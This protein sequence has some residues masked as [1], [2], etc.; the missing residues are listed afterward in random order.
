MPSFGP[1]ELRGRLAQG[2]L[3]EIYRA[4]R[5]SLGGIAHEVTLKWLRPE[6]ARVPARMQQLIEEA[7]LGVRLNHPALVRTEELIEVN[8][9]WAVVLEFVNGLDLM[10]LRRVLG[11]V[12]RS[13]SW[14]E[15]VYIAQRI[16]AGLEY[17][18]DQHRIVHGDLTPANVMLSVE[19]DVKLIDF[20]RPF[21]KDKEGRPI[22][23]GTPR[24]LAPETLSAGQLDAKSD[25]YATG[26]ILWELLSGVRVH[27]RRD[28]TDLPRS[29][30]AG[31]TGPLPL[32]DGAIPDPLIDMVEWLLEKDPGHR[33]PSA[34]LVLDRLETLIPPRSALRRSLAKT[35]AAAQSEL[36]S[37]D[38]PIVVPEP[39][40]EEELHSQL[41]S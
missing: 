4:R 34:A 22:V 5:Q 27:D 20:G 7:Q 37:T 25:L 39:S 31:G 33:P 23:G 16:V 12:Q 2:G 8:D 10:R 19:G 29:L 11:R 35:A 41:P 15:A 14:P 1:F 3:C 36:R 38:L 30:L 24:Y 17:L 28:S 32:P 18:H 9:D 21:G 26:L 13:L 6:H 40:L